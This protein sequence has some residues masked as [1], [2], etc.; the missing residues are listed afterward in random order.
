MDIGIFLCGF[1]AGGIVIWLWLEWKQ[2]RADERLVQVVRQI[3]GIRI[4]R[5]ARP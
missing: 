4:S 3:T 2:R 5:E 1:I